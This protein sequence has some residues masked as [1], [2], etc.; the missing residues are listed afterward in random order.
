MNRNKNISSNININNDINI[1]NNNIGINNNIL[2]WE[3][4]AR[5]KQKIPSG[6][7]FIWL[8]LA[9]RGF[10]KTRTGAES[11]MQLTCSCKYKSI[12]L[13]GKSITET[14]QIMIEGSSGILST[15]FAKII[16]KSKN[17]KYNLSFKYYSTKKQIEWNNGTIMYMLS[18]DKP[19]SIR[20]FQFDLVWIDEFAKFLNPS[21]LLQQVFFSLRLGN[22]PKC[23]ITTTPKPLKVLKELSD[24]KSVHVTNGSTFENEKYLSKQFLN[25]VTL[26]YNNTSIGRQELFGELIMEKENALWKR[27]N[28]QYK[29]VALEYLEKIVIGIDPAVTSNKNSDETGIVVAGLGIDNKMYI[30][31]DL[32][33]KYTGSEWAKIAVRA[34]IDYKVSYIVVE[35]NNGGELVIENL[36]S[37]DST[38]PIRTVHAV[39]GKVARA[40]PVSI[41]YESNRV[42]HFRE[43]NVLE[44]QM[45]NMSYDNENDGYSPDRVDALVWAISELRNTYLTNNNCSITLI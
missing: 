26:K 2:A 30:I 3:K 39:K 35:T 25:L 6:N 42:F 28:I 5:D 45:L 41:L 29:K 18:G 7:W 37:I 19:N 40:E 24:D 17:N 16:N 23:I 21:A 10:G 44:E 38:L 34:S 14:K 36:K 22:D 43:F 15:T 27:H 9:G 33:G 13:I 8:I 12:G 4:I 1:C 31:D 32:S 11:V 20:G